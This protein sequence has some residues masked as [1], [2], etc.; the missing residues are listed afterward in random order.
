[1]EIKV[2]IVILFCIIQF[3]LLYLCCKWEEYDAIIITQLMISNI[4]YLQNITK[5]QDQRHWWSCSGRE[6]NIQAP[7]SVVTYKR[8]VHSPSIAIYRRRLYV[9]GVNSI[10]KVIA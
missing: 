1:M 6:R 7:L 9:K 3:G 5:E 10:E 4:I 2:T 8:C